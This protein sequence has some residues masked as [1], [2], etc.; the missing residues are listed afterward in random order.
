MS[1]LSPFSVEE[2]KSSFGTAKSDHDIAN[3]DADPEV[4]V[5]VG[6]QTRIGPCQ[7]RLRFD[8]ALNGVNGAAELRQHAVPGGI[9]YPAPVG[10][11][12]AVKDTSP[13]DQVPHGPDLVGSHQAAVP[14]NVGSENR[15]QPTL[16]INH[17]CQNTPLKP[18][19]S[20]SRD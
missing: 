9:G 10:G 8:G 7:R 18:C 13:L 6:C 4:D 1:D 15:H 14:L 17:F 16:C 12:Q 2:R 5:T 11:N 19:D 20:L 3:V